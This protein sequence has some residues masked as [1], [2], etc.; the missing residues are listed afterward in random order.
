[1]WLKAIWIFFYAQEISVHCVPQ[2][3]TITIKV[4]KSL[5]DLY[6]N[7]LLVLTDK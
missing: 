4:A 1:M 2:F 7:T 6:L 3:F 5:G